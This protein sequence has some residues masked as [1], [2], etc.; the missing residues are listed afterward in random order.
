MEACQES[1]ARK[2]FRFRENGKGGGGARRTRLVRTLRRT[3][4]SA[5]AVLKVQIGC[6][7][8]Q[9]SPGGCLA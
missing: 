1:F 2:Q 4:Q 6:I 7:L 8:L 5:H 3:H 9:G